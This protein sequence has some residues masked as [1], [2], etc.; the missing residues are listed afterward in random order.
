LAYFPHGNGGGIALGVAV[1]ATAGMLATFY[2]PEPKKAETPGETAEQ[3][4]G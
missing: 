4:H 1:V 3:V 2:R